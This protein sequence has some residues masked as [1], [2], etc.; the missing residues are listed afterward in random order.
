ML[1]QRV[2]FLLLVLSSCFFLSAQDAGCRR[3][4]ATRIPSV[5]VAIQV[6]APSFLK[7]KIEA[8]H[9]T[10]A[11]TL[12]ASARILFDD[13]GQRISANANLI[14]VRDSVLWL[15][16]KKL[17]IEAVRALI[18]PDSVFLLNR[19]DK[20]W[21][22]RSIHDLQR[23]YG[24]PGGFDAVQHTLLGAAWL[25]PGQE[26]S[27]DISEGQHRLY[28]GDGVWAAEYRVEEGPYWLTQE[29]FLQKTEQRNAI[30]H[31]SGYKT[32][33]GGGYLPYLRRIE[34]FSPQSGGL[35]LEIELSNVEINVPKTWR[36]EVPAH[37]ERMD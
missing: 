30:L 36:F 22:A 34:T 21:A 14:W 37:Y 4:S 6:K 20:T 11:H 16:V 10:Y 31:F 27:S 3:K 1:M 13:G 28:G 23:A 26:W 25:L 15:N 33:P 29:S 17:G 24:L 7:E 5:K 32:L 19:L 12:S 18:T 8:P 35:T 2:R 9:L